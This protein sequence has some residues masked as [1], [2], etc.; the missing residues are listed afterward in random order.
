MTGETS[1]LSGWLRL[2]LAQGIVAPLIY[3][4]V[5]VVGGAMTPGYSNFH[6]AVSELTQG[7]AE[8]KEALV[9]ALVVMDLVT[10]A[11][12]I[13]Y[14]AV[15]RRLNRWLV[16]SGAMMVLT[17]VVGLGFATNPMDPVGSEMTPEGRMHLIIVSISALAAIIAVLSSALGWARLAS[18][19]WMAVFSATMLVMM[20]ITGGVSPFAVANEWPY[21]GLYQRLNT[22]AF[23]LWQILTALALMRLAA[24]ARTAPA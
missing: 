11:F 15:A 12:G 6:Q 24:G 20:L 14:V 18:W 17:G 23:G 19:R 4:G 9:V 3:L 16:L 21:I 8:N 7:G 10:I 5:I 2:A 22:G 13:G 1:R